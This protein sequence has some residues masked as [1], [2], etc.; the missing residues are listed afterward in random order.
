MPDLY[1][2]IVDVS[3]STPLMCTRYLEN[4]VRP[5]VGIAGLAKFLES[6]QIAIPVGSTAF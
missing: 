4:H 6:T 2:E 3:A 1:L 5:F